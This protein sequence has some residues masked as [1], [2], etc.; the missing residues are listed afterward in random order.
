MK[1]HKYR[2]FIKIKC[3]PRQIRKIFVK[4]L[5]IQKINLTLFKVLKL[6]KFY[7]N[8]FYTAFNIIMIFILFF[9]NY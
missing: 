9:L 6:L 5:F 3:E 2:L 4:S 1:V 7:A 8:S